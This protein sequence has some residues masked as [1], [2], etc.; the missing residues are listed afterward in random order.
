M[1]MTMVE[2]EQTLK[3]LRLSGIAATLEA[4]AMQASQ[5][6]MTFMDAF[7]ALL[8]D[9]MDRRRT[10]L[11]QRRYVLSGLKERKTMT[12]FDW[13][14][15]PK[16]P[17]GQ[18][19]ELMTAKFIAEKESAVLIGSPGTGKS[20]VAKA[21]ALA[22][23]TQEMRVYYRE[24]HALFEDLLEAETMGQKKKLMKTISEADLLIIDDLGLTKLKPKNGEDILEIV[25]DRYEKKSILITS[26]RIVSDWDKMLCD[27]TLA[28]AVLDR[29]MHHCQLLKFEG[30]SYRLKEAASRLNSGGEEKKDAA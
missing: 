9:E 19:L 27:A 23:I 20:H 1:P 16:L 12:G 6:E 7:S 5:G 26:N 3:K 29:L 11:L 2:I 30:K 8:Q 15:N 10:N 17:R 18:I 4:R 21:V 14:F 22:A 28:S 25:M 24:A 13:N